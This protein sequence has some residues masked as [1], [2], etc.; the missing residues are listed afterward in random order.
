MIMIVFI[1]IPCILYLYLDYLDPVPERMYL[2][3]L[4]PVP[5]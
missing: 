1:L 2:E 4:D 5:D 3:N